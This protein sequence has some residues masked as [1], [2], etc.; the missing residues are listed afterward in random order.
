MYSSRSALA[1]APYLWQTLSMA[2]QELP[3]GFPFVQCGPSGSAA[4][5][6]INCLRASSLIPLAYV[7]Q[8]FIPAETRRGKKAQLPHRSGGRR[9][10]GLYKERDGPVTAISGML[11]TPSRPW[12]CLRCKSARNRDP[13]EMGRTTL[14]IT[15]ESPRG[16]GPDRRRSGPRPATYSAG[17]SNAFLT[18]GVGSRLG[19]ETQ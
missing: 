2:M 9:S 7:L 10:N 18:F 13:G 4:P 15:A 6:L 14:D 16:G 12:P 19:A 5:P 3:H 11:V 8:S 17:D 1:R